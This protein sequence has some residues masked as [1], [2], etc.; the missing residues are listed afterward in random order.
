M[1]SLSKIFKTAKI[2][3]S[4][5]IIFNESGNELWQAID[6]IRFKQCCEK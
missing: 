5:N 1:E 4:L 2:D 3:E 6:V